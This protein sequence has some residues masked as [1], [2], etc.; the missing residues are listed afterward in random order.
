LPAVSTG[1]SLPEERKSSA[2][3]PCYLIGRFPS[4]M[5]DCGFAISGCSRFHATLFIMMSYDEFVK[6]IVIKTFDREALRGRC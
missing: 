4:A 2:W 3:L 6:V 1:G 5:L